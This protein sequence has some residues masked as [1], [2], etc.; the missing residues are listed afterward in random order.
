M[1]ANKNSTPVLIQASDAVSRPRKNGYDTNDKRGSN[2][3]YHV[4]IQYVLI[5][6]TLDMFFVWNNRR[7]LEN[8]HS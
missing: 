3:N 1:Q 7:W 8:I 4:P 2:P 5:L 6:K